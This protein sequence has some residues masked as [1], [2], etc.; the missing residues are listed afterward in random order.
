MEP[1]DIIKKGLMTFKKI[2]AWVHLW[3]GLVSGIIVVIVSLT[4]CILVFEQEIRDLT[5]PWLFAEQPANATVLPPSAILEKVSASIPNK[6]VHSIWY[7]GAGQTAKVSIE[8]SDSTVF[9]NPYTG[10]IVAMVDHED[11][12]HFILEGHTSLWMENELGQGIITY[13]TLIFFI[14]LIS[15][16]ILWWPKKWTRSTREKSFKIKWSAKFKRV[17]YDLHN[18]LGFYSLLV[19]LIITITGLTMGFSWFSKSVYWLTSGGG[20]P[21]AFIRASTDTTK[22]YRVAELKNVDMAWKMA[23]TRIGTYNKDAV[24]VTFPEKPSDPIQLCVDMKNGS[25][26]YVN[27]DQH[28]LKELPSTQPPIDS[29]EFADWLRR[30]NYGMHVGSIGGMITKVL[31][32]LA[33]LISTTLPITG[34]Y[35]WWGKRKKSKGKNI[36]KVRHQGKIAPA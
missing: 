31:F 4:G 11:F 2:N 19:A 21:P 23:T 12:F 33:S 22:I 10:D 16:L 24:I 17:N 14:L 27:L 32:F 3:F 6:A 20:T 35:V 30:V 25:W 9:V 13:A 7:N 18:V 1:G 34:F 29:L 15:G 36:S 28:T 26:R 5:Q 8:D